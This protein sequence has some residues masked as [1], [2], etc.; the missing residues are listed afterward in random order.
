METELRMDTTLDQLFPA[1]VEA[2]T[3]I[4]AGYLA[5]R[6]RVMPL[7]QARG[8]GQ[9][10]SKFAL[11]A[12]LFLNMCELNFKNVNWMFLLSILIAKT[13]VFFLVAILTL[14][15]LRP[16]HWGKTGLYA[17]F[18]TQSNDFALGYPIGE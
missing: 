9:Y 11:P 1:L 18:A 4:C 12:L 5:G 17:I 2:F 14:L 3:I 16:V 15:F 10:I 6:F 13:A 8:L 7:V